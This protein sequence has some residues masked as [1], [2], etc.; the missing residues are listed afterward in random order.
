MPT[1]NVSYGAALI[2]RNRR[3]RAEVNRLEAVN[4]GL[5]ASLEERTRE[6]DAARAGL[7]HELTKAK[8]NR[9]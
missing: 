1:P 8:G 4:E 5:R 9:G 6:R 2:N 7:R 3:L